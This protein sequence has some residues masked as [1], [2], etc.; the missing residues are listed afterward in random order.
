MPSPLERT[1]DILARRSDETSEAILNAA[2]GRDDAVGVQ[3]AAAVGRHAS[4]RVKVDLV[5]RVDTLSAAQRQALHSAPKAFAEAVRHALESREADERAAAVRWVAAIEDFE[6]YPTLLKRLPVSEADDLPL[7]TQ[8]L[9][10]LCDRMFDHLDGRNAACPDGF[11]LRNAR[12]LRDRMH[13]GLS[14][15]VGD[16][17]RLPCP[18]AVLEWAFILADVEG[19]G[20]SRVVGKVPA[21]FSDRMHA[22]LRKSVHPGVM[23]LPLELLKRAYPTDFVYD[24][25]RERGDEPY[26]HWLLGTFPEKLTTN[27]EKNLASVDFVPWLRGRE[28]ELEELPA[29]Y[30]VG[31]A[32]VVA[33]LGL[34]ED[35]KRRTLRWLLTHG[36]GATRDA[37]TAG[38]GLLDR[39]E[40]HEILRESLEHE[41]S[42]V[43][44]WATHNLRPQAV[45]DAF[46]LLVQRLDSSDELVLQ[47]ARQEL[48]DINLQ[49]AAEMLE[50]SPTRVNADFGR[51]LEKINP[52]V[53]SELQR[54]LAHPIRG[55]RV[56]ALR[57]TAALG[58]EEP[59]LAA[60]LASADDADMLVRRT[61]LTVLANVPHRASLMAIRTAMTD[62]SGRV[63]ETAAEALHQL[64]RT[65]A[66]AVAAEEAAEEAAVS[67]TAAR[68]TGERTTHVVAKA[69]AAPAKAEV[70]R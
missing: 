2:L 12:E 35:V 21:E 56:T 42:T 59:M 40:S 38:F 37:A 24:L 47:A 30:H 68:P 58:M 23:R 61:A 9:E 55:R 41:D 25:W 31:L 65:M 52:D 13:R 63:R 7:L 33:V 34:G 70:S 20:V 10:L 45:P 66:H 67:E 16:L 15:A 6:Q 18:E 48:A 1:F 49:K 27:Q 11:T 29:G 62:R 44:A 5:R 43:Q 19:A 46:T 3:A 28:G 22:T 57:L 69:A 26:V 64:R 39:A 8:T 50:S 60:L 14:E 51:L 32:R 53:L 54:E 17:S 4:L 36:D